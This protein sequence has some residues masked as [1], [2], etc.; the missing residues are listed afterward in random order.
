MR[1]TVKISDLFQEGVQYLKV[2]LNVLVTYTLEETNRS[3]NRGKK[4]SCT[5]SCRYKLQ[6]Y[7][8]K[9]VTFL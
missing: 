7:K 8:R 9:S 2:A 1:A 4:A 6:N 5:F 3:L